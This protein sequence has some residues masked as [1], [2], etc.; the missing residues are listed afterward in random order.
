LVVLFGDY[1]VDGVTS[2][3]LLEEVLRHLGWQVQ[4]YLPNRMEEGYGLGQTAALNCVQQLSPKLILAVDCGSTSVATI[5]WL[6][7]QGVDV[8]VLDHHQFGKEKPAAVALV[9]PWLA[10]VG[11]GGKVPFGELCSVGLAFKLAHALVKTGRKEGW[12]GALDYDVRPLLDLVALG[13]IADMVPLSGENRILVT[14]GLRRLNQTV[15]PGLLALR[16]AA[17]LRDEIGTYEVGFQLGPRLNAAGRLEDATEA[18]R[19]LQA[20]KRAEAQLLAKGLDDRN[21]ERQAIE[22]GM[23]EEIMKEVEQGFDPARDFVIVVGRS[24]WHIGVV[25]IA[26]SRVLQRFYRPV[27]ILGGDGEHWRGSGRSIEGFDLA[28]ALRQCDSLLIKHGG[29]PMAAGITLAPRE[30]AAFR[31]QLND[32]A[33]EA[34]P[35]ESLTPI[36]RIDANLS[37]GETDLS[38][39]AEL[40][41]LRPTGQ[42]NPSVHLVACG[43]T[44]RKPLMRMGQEKQHVKMW[45]TDGTTVCEAVWWGAGHGELPVGDFDLAFEPQINDYNGVRRIQ[46]KVLDWRSAAH[47]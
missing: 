30:L 19:L 9:N 44:H 43:L 11:P 27:I 22:R 42:G 45:V 14:A 26:A 31:Q 40:A 6:Q 10:P 25:G 39:M 38:L 28:A 3:A 1:D 13:T 34:L 12:P 29:H 41:R 35:A 15:R 18:L 21:R 33:R 17:G 47:G 37:L 36:L 8:V 32:L 5:A 24:D 23:V 4:C 16:E 20:S 7:G 2:C 46:L